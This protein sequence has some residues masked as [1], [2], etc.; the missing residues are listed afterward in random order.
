MY[1]MKWK[2]KNVKREPKK[3]IKKRID[4]GQVITRENKGRSGILRSL[5]NSLSGCLCCAEGSSPDMNI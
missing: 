5:I 1:R 3:P 2:E 4:D